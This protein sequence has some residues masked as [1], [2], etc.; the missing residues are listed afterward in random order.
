MANRGTKWWAVSALVALAA[1]A[2]PARAQF[3]P[4]SAA[5]ARLAWSEVRPAG[6]RHVVLLNGVALGAATGSFWGI[7]PPGETEFAPG[8]AVA[9]ARVVSAVQGSGRDV[10]AALQAGEGPVAAGSRAVKVSPPMP[11]PRIPVRI[12]AAAPERSAALA[13]ALRQALPTLEVVGQEGF[14]RF[15]IELKETHCLV[16]DAGGRA[17]IGRWDAC[18]TTALAGQLSRLLSRSARSA[19]LLALDNPSSAIRLE[20]RVA[21]PALPEERKLGRR[22][23]QVQA[24]P[25]PP[26]YRVRRQGDPR[27]PMNSLQLEIRASTEVYLTIADVDAEGKVNLLFPNQVQNEQFYPLGLIPGGEMVRIPDSLD[28]GNRAAFNWDLSPPPGVDTIR[29]FASKSR[30]TAQL[31][32]DLIREAGSADRPAETPAATLRALQERLA[33]T[34]AT[35][36]LVHSPSSAAQSPGPGGDWAATSVTITVKE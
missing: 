13:A 29:V 8:A 7:Y 3:S 11:G 10:L 1:V 6:Q 23:V 2:Q 33:E 19:E 36:A 4:E 15:V 18:D 31:I 16:F 21:H 14:A 35:R 9:V 24:N 30:E 17:E 26:E 32:R 34:A 28:L 25:R 27:L 20:V 22:G 5:A 12:L